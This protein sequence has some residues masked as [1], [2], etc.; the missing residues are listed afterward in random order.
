MEVLINGKTE[1]L[2]DGISAAEL[3][4]QLGLANERLAMEVNREIVPRS[5]FDSHCF[6]PGDKIEIV[7][8]IGGGSG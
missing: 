6:N 1:Q 4:E 5:R 8:A 7:R 2:P 3:I